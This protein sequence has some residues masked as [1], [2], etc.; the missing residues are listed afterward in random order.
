[1]KKKKSSPRAWLCGWQQHQ[2]QQV[3]PRTRII[4]STRVDGR[5]YWQQEP[6]EHKRQLPRSIL[7]AAGLSRHT[8]AYLCFTLS[9]FLPKGAHENQTS[10]KA[11]RTQNEAKKKKPHA[12][13]SQN[14][15][16]T[17]QTTV[18]IVRVAAH[19]NCCCD[20]YDEIIPY[21]VCVIPVTTAAVG[22]AAAAVLDPSFAA[23][24]VAAA[25]SNASRMAGCIFVL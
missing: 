10:S 7:H 21:V 13:P 25:L 23:T 12:Q 8:D 4:Y 14:T 17:T 22:A 24:V 16:Q 11:P 3:K 19:N 15:T 1:M 2:Q 6:F 18:F 5:R 9:L 20:T